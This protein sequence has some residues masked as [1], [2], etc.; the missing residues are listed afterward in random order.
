MEKISG[1]YS[2]VHSESC[3]VYVGSAVNLYKREHEHRFDLYNNCHDNQRLQNAWNKYG[4]AA[5]KFE[6]LEVVQDPSNLLIK[7]QWWM[8][9]LQ[10]YDR[11]KGFNIRKVAESNFGLKH[12]PETL[13]KIRQGSIGKNKDKVGD[14][15]HF[16]GKKHTEESLAKMRTPRSEEVKQKFSI[17]AQKRW[18][19]HTEEKI[20]PNCQ[21]SFNTRLS[22]DNDFCSK[23]CN[24]RYHGRLRTQ[25]NTIEKVCLLC[26]NTFRTSISENKK[27]CSRKCWAVSMKGNKNQSK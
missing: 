1:I 2:I 4:E 24:N 22:D 8:D 25:N 21:I 10:S 14:K 17:A 13:E 11:D 5:F 9:K 3:K 19:G 12:T 26:P 6:V 23:K 18:E 27:Y 20:C 7:E 16:F 15:N